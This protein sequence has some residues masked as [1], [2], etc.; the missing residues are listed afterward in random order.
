MTDAIEIRTVDRFAEPAFTALVD[1]LLHDSDRKAVNERLFGSQV[2]APPPSQALQ[3]R[4]GAYAG[5]TLV[6]WSHAFL[7][8]GGVL[9]VSNSAVDHEYRRQGVYTRLVAAIEEEAKALHC[10][11]VESHHRAA[12]SA[13]LIAK[14]KAG[15]TIVGTEFQAEMGLLVKMAKPLDARRGAV[16]HARAGVLEGAVRFF[17]PTRNPALTGP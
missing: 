8:P 17:E 3:V 1:R 10:L 12:N 13:V 5:D 14:L 16:F 2:V 6:G 4:V 7:A 15:Y 11:R 9:Y